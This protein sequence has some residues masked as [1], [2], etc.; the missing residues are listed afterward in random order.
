MA[1]SLSKEDL[2]RLKKPSE[3]RTSHE[4]ANIHQWL[5]KRHPCVHA[6]LNL[7]WKKANPKEKDEILRN[8]FIEEKQPGE[9]ITQEQLAM[10][11]K[12]YIIL[13]GT[14]TQTRTRDASSDL[15]EELQIG[16]TIGEAE[17]LAFVPYYKTTIL[18]D[19]ST[20]RNHNGV[21]YP[22]PTYLLSLPQV[23]YSKQIAASRRKQFALELACRYLKHIHCL[24]LLP[25]YELNYLAGQMERRI[26]RK[27]EY[28]FAAGQPPELFL[29]DEG[30]LRISYSTRVHKKEQQR[31][32]SFQTRQVELQILSRFDT[33]GLAE[34]NARVSKFEYDCIA[35]FETTVYHVPTW[36]W[37]AL[38]THSEFQNQIERI[39]QAQVTW[40]AQRRALASNENTSLSELKL[41]MPMQSKS[42]LLCSQCGKDGCLKHHS[43]G[44]AAFPQIKI[45]RKTA[46]RSSMP[47]A[48]QVPIAAASSRLQCRRHTE[49]SAQPTNL[50]SLLARMD[51]A[52][53]DK[54]FEQIVSAQRPPRGA[55][56]IH[57]SARHAVRRLS[58]A[59]APKDNI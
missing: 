37:R 39:L 6:T 8:L 14:C 24:S 12:V 44:G 7:W 32:S 46:K 42:P 54:P 1:I 23:I 51:A 31:W 59:P 49:V 36:V 34:I 57:L 33:V 53:M 4:L 2:V 18:A 13:T 11:D 55:R 40:F 20:L 47:D 58:L 10:H 3:Q 28:L 5:L 38:S 9:K 41:T 17:L 43:W 25:H 15:S 22:A 48:M 27:N 56:D 19:G 16:Q 52:I 50:V 30:Q 29:V 35:A 21:S 45:S 26:I